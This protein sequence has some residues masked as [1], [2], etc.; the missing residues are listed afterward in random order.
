MTTK[1]LLKR[2]N[3]ASTQPAPG[4]VAFG[5]LAI[6]YEDGILYYKTAAGAIDVIARKQ[7]GGT[8]GIAISRK[9]SNYTATDGDFLIADT[10]D[11]AWTLTLPP[12]PSVGKFVTIFDGGSWSTTPLLINPNGS[13]IDGS[14]ASINLDISNMRVD[15]VYNGS[16]WKVYKPVT[17]QYVTDRLAAFED[18]VITYAIA[19]G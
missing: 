15:F 2:S 4:D 8:S 17:E 12:S 6:N 16:T 1:I 18:D 9:V 7:V 5:E 14:G 19:L 3:V 13:T 10:S 11:G